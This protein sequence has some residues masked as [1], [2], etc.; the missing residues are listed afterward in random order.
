[1][2]EIKARILQRAVFISGE[3]L[4]CELTITNQGRTKRDSLKTD[5]KYVKSRQSAES[6]CLY[7]PES[8]TQN[9][10]NTSKPKDIEDDSVTLAWASA[11]IYCH[12]NINERKLHLPVNL[13]NHKQ[14]HITKFTSFSP[15]MGK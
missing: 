4:Q 3:C 14:D 15:V 8:W 2:I 11:Q 10:P 6:V 1:M 13:H 7:E 12:C 9:I 5:E